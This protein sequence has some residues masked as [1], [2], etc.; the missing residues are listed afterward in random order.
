M[1]EITVECYAAST[2]DVAKMTD[3]INNC[4]R[5]D[6]NDDKLLNIIIEEAEAYFA[7][8]KTPEDVAKIVQSRA[9]IYVNENR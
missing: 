8:Q 2:D 5:I 3:I 1:G 9:T 7:G 6:A 4:D